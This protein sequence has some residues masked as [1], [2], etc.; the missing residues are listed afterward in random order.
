MV[1]FQFST[2]SQSKFLLC[3]EDQ[4]LTWCCCSNWAHMRYWCYWFLSILVL[5]LFRQMLLQLNGW[6]DAQITWNHQYVWQDQP[7]SIIIY[8]VGSTGNLGSP[9]HTTIRDKSQV[10]DLVLIMPFGQT[11]LVFILSSSFTIKFA[12]C[13]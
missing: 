1:H 3:R 4:L 11:I 12:S 2:Y 6:R 9:S 5:F 8:H 7:I 13:H 10:Y